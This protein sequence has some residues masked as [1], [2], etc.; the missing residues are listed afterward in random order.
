M[1]YQQSFVD[2]VPNLLDGTIVYI[3]NTDYTVVVSVSNYSFPNSVVTDLVKQAP[4]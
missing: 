4:K 3:F 2:Q 1:G